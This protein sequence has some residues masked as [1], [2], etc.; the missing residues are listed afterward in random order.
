MGMLEP[1]MTYWN[2]V[3]TIPF[4]FLAS[5]RKISDSEIQNKMISKETDEMVRTFKIMV[6][7][8]RLR[9]SGSSQFRTFIH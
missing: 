5:F 1:D 6:L 2:I 4:P 7:S 9:S 3:F 8:F